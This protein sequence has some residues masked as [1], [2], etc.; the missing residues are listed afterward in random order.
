[1]ILGF[2]LIISLFRGKSIYDKI[3]VQFEVS[4]RYFSTV[5]VDF[6]RVRVR[7]A[8]MAGFDFA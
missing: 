2:I 8:T 1:M 6:M 7:Q 4:H 5:D 3:K